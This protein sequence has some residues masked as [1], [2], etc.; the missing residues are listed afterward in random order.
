MLTI[1]SMYH[2]GTLTFDI[3]TDFSSITI[4]AVTGVGT[5]VPALTPK[6][7]LPY[8]ADIKSD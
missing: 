5:V 4:D 7:G 1:S 3:I 2:V 6:G 8:C